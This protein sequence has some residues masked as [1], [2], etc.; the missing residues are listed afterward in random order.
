MITVIAT[1]LSIIGSLNWLLVGIFGLDV[2]ALIF[3]SAAVVGARIIYIL[4]GLSA[5]WLT[6]YLIRVRARM[7]TKY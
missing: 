2:I 6:A 5:V 3:G 4:I 7:G 1:I